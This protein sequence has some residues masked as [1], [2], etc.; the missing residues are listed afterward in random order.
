M[1]GYAAEGTAITTLGAEV[2]SADDI[3][4]SAVE[5]AVH[6]F[7]IFP[8]HGKIPAIG[9]AHRVGDPLRGICK[10]GCGRNG[11]GLFDA[12]SDIAQ[13]EAWWLGA[14]RG[15]NI[16]IRLPANVFVVDTDP[17]NGGAESVKNLEATYGPFP[18]T[19]TVITGRGDGGS[20][21]YYRRPSGKITSSI[22]AGIDIKSSTGYCV[23]PPSIHPDSGLPYRWIEAPIAEPQWI[24]D[25][26]R[27]PRPA[28]QSIVKRG[29]VLGGTSIADQFTESTSWAQ[30]LQPHGWRCIDADG[31]CDGARWLHPAATSASSATIRNGCLFVYSPNTPFE[32]TEPADPHGYTRFRAWAVLEHR[33]D[34]SAAAKHFKSTGTL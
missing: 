10:G 19:L 24:G 2:L 6:G 20:H 32:I 33:G 21:R 8:L 30:I 22:G 18:G 1:T 3:G 9:A 12:T 34:L 13:I 5:L 15:A 27:P 7:T 29:N 4:V 26:I 16:G 23:A 17:R 31:D 28:L 25:L 14:Y 11:H